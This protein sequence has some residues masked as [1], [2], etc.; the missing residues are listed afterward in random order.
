MANNKR[1]YTIYVHIFPD[2]KRYVGCTCTSVKLRWNGGLG[3]ERQK[4]VFS[5]ILKFGWNNIRH[6]IIMENLS[7]EEALLYESAFIHS[8]KTYTKSKG[9]NTLATNIEGADDINIPSFD[10][11][12]KRLVDDFYDDNIA[13][14]CKRKYSNSNHKT[15]PVRCIETGQ[16]FKSA[17]EAATFCGN[18]NEYTIYQS[19]MKKHA[20]GTCYIYDD[21]IGYEREVP[22]HWEYID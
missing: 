20:S 18:G 21:E 19:I 4:K 12:G 15:T 6:Y 7:R 22:A 10:D 11:C 16:V 2:G 9:Y 1:N 14:R 3:Y 8:W 13:D 5:A 17:R